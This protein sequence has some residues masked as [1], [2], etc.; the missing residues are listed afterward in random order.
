MK[1]ILCL[2][3]LVLSLSVGRV[4]AQTSIVPKG[5]IKPERLEGALV[6]MQKQLDTG[7]A[8][9]A[10]AWSMADVA[11]AELF[12][13]YI[14]LYEK[15]PAKEREALRKEQEIWL[16]KREKAANAADDG[17]SGQIGHLQ[18]ASEHHSMT[19]LRIQELKARLPKKK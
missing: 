16:K 8:M 3:L 9:L 19:D 6:P 14:D 1:S 7:I 2:V 17:Q 10:T 15:L 18:S 4:H 11:D 5:W 13:I 12:V